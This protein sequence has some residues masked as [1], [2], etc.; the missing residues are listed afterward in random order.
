MAIYVDHLE[1]WGWQLRGRTVKSCHLFTDE[2]DLAALHRM[3]A[4]IGMKRAWF[5]DKPIAPHYDLV[6]SR[7]AHAIELGAV[8]VDRHQ[9]VAIWRLRRQALAALANEAAP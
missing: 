1:S 5:Q 9:A 3:A 6:A 7:R 4:D 2:L 8:E